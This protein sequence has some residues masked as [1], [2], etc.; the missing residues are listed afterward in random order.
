MTKK[1]ITWRVLMFFIHIATTVV[2]PTR[3]EGRSRVPKTGKALIVANH[4]SFLD[5]P[6]LTKAA[7]HR[8]LAF[9]A[10]ATLAESAVFAF[11]MR[12][13]GAILIDRDRGDRAALRRMT[14]VLEAGGVVVIFPEGRRT[15]DGAIAT[16]KKGALL[17]ARLAGAPIVPCAV[18]G[19]FAAWPPSRRF[20][21]PGRIS[22]R[23]G[24]P[25]PSDQGD[26]LD[27]TWEQIRELLGGNQP[28]RD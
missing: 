4:Q 26:A 16:P 21:R 12:H 10:R 25:V 20:P 1:G 19:S 23:F 2:W 8:H 6:L 22:V 28:P 27:A 5:I 14:E 15:R 24:V 3:V 13:C 18:D 11:V 7:H 17:A 9:V